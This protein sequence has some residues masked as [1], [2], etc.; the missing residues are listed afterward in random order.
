MFVLFS[1]IVSALRLG[2]WGQAMKS[3]LCYSFF[4]AVRICSLQSERSCARSETFSPCWSRENWG[5]STKSTEKRGRVDTGR[6]AARQASALV[7][8]IPTRRD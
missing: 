1:F 8:F 2:W 5:E 6:L 7:A 3:F 4:I